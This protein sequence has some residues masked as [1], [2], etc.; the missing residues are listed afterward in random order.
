MARKSR[1]KHKDDLRKVNH[2]IAN[3]IAY[4]A[5]KDDKLQNLTNDFGGGPNVIDK[6]A[7]KLL[8][9][10]HDNERY[11]IDFPHLAAPLS[12]SERSVW[13][14][15]VLK[16]LAGENILL[17]S[18]R[19]V[20]FQMNSR[21]GD[22]LTNHN[23]RDKIVNQDAYIFRYH[24]EFQ[25]LYLNE[26]IYKY[27][28]I[29]NLEKQREKY[30]KEALQTQGG[31]KTWWW[32]GLYL[33]IGSVLSAASLFL[34]GKKLKSSLEKKLENQD[35]G[36]FIRKTKRKVVEDPKI[37]FQKRAK[38]REKKRKKSK[39]PV[40]R[41]PLHKTVRKRL[42][43]SSFKKIYRTRIQKK[44]SKKIGRRTKFFFRKR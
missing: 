32:Y 6:E 20:F 24:P 39:S 23:K 15:D 8:G 29:E 21:V 26:K 36:F 41:L 1:E 43:K 22:A 33:F 17:L 5:Y 27:Y 40:P 3:A 31:E 11:L 10:I 35:L 13:W 42:K 37:T 34:I 25:G 9:E 4:P 7:E 12:T 14:K 18:P 30:Y 38:E 28:H 2:D 19:D 44:I 16:V